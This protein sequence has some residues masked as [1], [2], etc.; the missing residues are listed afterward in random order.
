MNNKN[1]LYKK[2]MNYYCDGKLEKSLYFCDKVLELER[3]HSPTLNLKGLIYYVQGN[4]EQAKFF[5]K[6]SYKL[7]GDMVSKKYL[8]D[9]KKD[10]IDLYVFKQGVALLNEYKVRE[11]LNCFL[12]CQG[13]HFNSINLWAYLAKCYMQL[14]EYK[15]SINY[16]NDILSLDIKNQ[17][18]L[19]IKSQLIELGVYEERPKAR[20]S[21]SLILVP[22]AL[23]LMLLLGAGTYKGYGFVKNWL[24]NKQR[25]EAD[26]IGVQEPELDNFQG[27]IDENEDNKEENKD[28]PH[29]DSKEVSTFNGET[30]N[31]YITSK[32]FEEIIK[33]V[34]QYKNDELSINNKSLIQGAID[35]IVEDGVESIYNDAMELI[36]DKKYNEAIEKLG[37]AYQYSSGTYLNEHILFM[38]ASAYDGLKN[39]ETANRYYEI[40]VEE[41]LKEGSYIQQCLY[42]L[43]IN[44]NEIDKEKSKKYAELLVEHYSDSEFN[45]S[46]IKDIVSR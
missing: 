41:Y 13:S 1:K 30:L 31:T 40:Y 6:L 5:W 11:A 32:N 43:A 45:N 34:N 29:D 33:Y 19:H 27:N 24:E 35:L 25:V 3:G 38:M 44:N 37:L 26:N 9:T 17:E 15:R 8:D 2:A 22:M 42:S 4:L 21:K 14:G 28:E 46:I 36:Q 20:N 18:A 39:I 10:E 23:L 7:N 16:I 12:K